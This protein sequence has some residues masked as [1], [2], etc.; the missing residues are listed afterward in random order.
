MAS[1]DTRTRKDGTTAYR[2]RWR[3]GGKRDGA[4][5]TVTYDDR[6][7]ARKM[8]GAVEA[9]GH[10]V[11]DSDPAVVDFSLVTGMR[12]QS[13]TA[14]LYKDVAEMW[15]NSRT[16]ASAAT[17]DH[18]RNTVSQRHTALLNRPI[19]SITDDDLNVMFNEIVEAGLSPRHAYEVAGSVFRYAQNKGKDWLTNGN[20]MALVE[21]P[22]KAD[23]SGV[24]LLPS[25]SRLLL[26]KCD[27]VEAF[28]PQ[29]ARG[30]SDLVDTYLGTG[31]RRSEALGLIRAD[32]IFPN[33]SPAEL[34]ALDLDALDDDE[35]ADAL[36]GAYLDVTRQLSAEGTRRVRLKTKASRRRV[37]LDL[38]TALIIAR[39][40]QGRRD[41]APVFPDPKTGGWWR[42]FNVNKLWAAARD[43]AM[44]DG[45]AKQVPPH[46]R[47]A[48]HARG[49]A[50]HGQ[51]AVAGRVAPARPRI[52]P[53]HGRHVRPPVAGG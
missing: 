26:D 29:K 6:D 45:L 3:F 21:H 4:P 13:Y 1:I 39:R 49:V 10:L 35:L 41:D 2:L 50:D 51:C 8:K 28:M 22:G 43:A 38:D 12:Q 11:Y 19:E 14:P 23:K 46:P 40:V 34:D 42:Q 30:L 20:P 52:H 27:A 32:V 47:L 33:L 17:R 25:E 37:V 16:R 36:D 9:R 7:D 15:I 5:Q 31:L 53:D 48:A 18:Y 44:A 24:F